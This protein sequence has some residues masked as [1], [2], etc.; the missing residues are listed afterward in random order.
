M[1]RQKAKLYDDLYYEIF[2]LLT[3][4]V[5]ANHVNYDTSFYKESGYFPYYDKN[6]CNRIP[7]NFYELLK[8]LHFYLF[9][10][11][12]NSRINDKNDPFPLTI[13]EDEKLSNIHD[14]IIVWYENH[15]LHPKF[16]QAKPNRKRCYRPTQYRNASFW[17]WHKLR[18]KLREWKKE[19]NIS[20]H[21]ICVD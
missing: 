19:N 12:L 16:N 10:E 1:A 5:L 4:W 15:R 2:S 17:L 18:K 21:L 9:Y 13:L 6:D 8:N 20:Y 3:E 14:K 11:K 7:S